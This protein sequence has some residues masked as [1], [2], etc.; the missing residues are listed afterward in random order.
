[1]SGWYST[2]YTMRVPISVPVLGGSGTPG[3]YDM[4][5]TVPKDWDLFWDNIR[6]DGFDVIV[7]DADNSIATFKR[8]SFTYSTR[9]LDMAVDNLT[10]DNNDSV[11]LL[12][13][14][15]SYSGASDLAS[16]FTP[17]SPKSGLLFLGQPNNRIVEYINPQSTATST[18]QVTFSKATDESVFIWFQTGSYLANRRTPYNNRRFFEGIKFVKGIIHPKAGTSST[19]TVDE[20]K[21]R[22]IDGWTGLLIEGGTDATN[23]TVELK[24]TTT[25]NQVFSIRCGIICRDRIPV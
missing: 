22:F 25:L 1:M 5:W 10:V 6:S 15:F 2:N 3:A 8:A 17:S 14:Y 19:L 9:T 12:W 11:N 13:M 24:V 20:E 16:V 18:P 4:S 7:T 21:T 23:Y